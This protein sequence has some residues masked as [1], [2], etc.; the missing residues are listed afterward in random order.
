MPFGC[1]SFYI[2]CISLPPEKYLQNLLR[3]HLYDVKQKS[4]V[5]KIGPTHTL[6]STGV[7]QLTRGCSLFVHMHK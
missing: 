4:D 5:L 2:H 7:V 6:Y 1:D 3:K